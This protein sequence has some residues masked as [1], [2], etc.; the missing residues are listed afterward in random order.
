MVAPLIVRGTDIS[1][2]AEHNALLE[3]RIADKRVC[4]YLLSGRKQ[5]LSARKPA[6]VVRREWGAR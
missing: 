5:R 3:D 2:A 6:K 1:S 4:Q